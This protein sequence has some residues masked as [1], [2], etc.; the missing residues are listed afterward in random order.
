FDSRTL[1]D[2][3]EERLAISRVVARIVGGFGVLALVLAALGLY[4]VVVF[5]VAG[6]TREIG[7]RVAL[8]ARPRTVVAEIVRDGLGLVALG[9]ISGA[10][11]AIG[12]GRVMAS[13][14]DGM[15]GVDPAAA[16]AAAALLLTVAVIASWIPARRAARVDPLQAL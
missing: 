5:T 12:V 3:F 15:P 14:V 2:R 9:L 7:I 1:E 10:V 13:V 11:C 4:G 16:F 6:R 8:G